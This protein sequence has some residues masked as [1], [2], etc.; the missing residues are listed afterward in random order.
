MR[1]ANW[2]EG[3]VSISCC[4]LRLFQHEEQNLPWSE[5]LLGDVAADRAIA[6]GGHRL[7]IELVV[8]RLLKVIAFPYLLGSAVWSQRSIRSRRKSSPAGAAAQAVAG[9]EGVRMPPIMTVSNTSKCASRRSP[10]RSLSGRLRVIYRL[11]M[12]RA[13]TPDQSP[14]GCACDQS[15]RHRPTAGLAQSWE[16]WAVAISTPRGR[17]RALVE[18]GFLRLF[19]ADDT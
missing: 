17:R 19:D 18:H 15:T 9:D 2:L 7:L 4:V 16:S 5:N 11:A 12:M 10:H 13:R 8:R 14:F 6:P 3:K 1:R